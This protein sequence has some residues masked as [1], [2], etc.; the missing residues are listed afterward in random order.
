MRDYSGFLINWLPNYFLLQQ[1]HII[2]NSLSFL[3]VTMHQSRQI[4][5]KD[6]TFFQLLE[7][8]GNYLI[9]TGSKIKVFAEITWFISEESKHL[10][11]IKNIVSKAMGCT[12]CVTYTKNLVICLCIW[13]EG[14]WFTGNGISELES[15]IWLGKTM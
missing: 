3:S 8:C 7:H 4:L 1:T 11:F 14:L 6:I 10:T 12:T 9:S 2:L 15:K 5:I 13:L